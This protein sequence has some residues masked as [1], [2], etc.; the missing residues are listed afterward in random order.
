MRKIDWE[1]LDITNSF[2]FGKVMLNP[3]I[4]KELL[5]LILEIK[6]DHIEYPMIEK[7]IKMLYDGKGIR[8]DVYVA[9]GK[10]TVYNVEMQARNTKE[11]PKRSRYYQGIIDM[12]LLEQ[13]A[14]YNDLNKSYTIF[15]CTFDLFEKGRC[16]YTFENRC[17]ED[18]S[19][20]L[21]DDA[22]RIFLNTKGVLEDESISEDLRAFLEFVEGIEND[23]A[24]VSKVKSEVEV[25]KSDRKVRG[26]YMNQVV[27][28][29]L[30]RDEGFEKGKE[31]GKIEERLAVLRELEYS[32]NQI[33]EKLMERF[34]LS[35]EVA[36]AYMK[37]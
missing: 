29:Q 5:E 18:T 36:Q 16:R 26:E 22:I 34:G 28:D 32:S 25:V 23:N 8:L 35:E 17:V 2:I 11:L 12:E 1:K 27:R 10:N 37:K 30:N 31:I 33:V 19:I 4:C 7:S 9:D 14:V 6:I 15:I 13:G 21:D 24:F 3:D 20:R